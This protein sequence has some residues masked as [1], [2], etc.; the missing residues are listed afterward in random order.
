[1]LHHTAT[2]TA[3]HVLVSLLHFLYPSVLRAEKYLISCRVFFTYRAL[4]HSLLSARSTTDAPRTQ[5][6]PAR[7]PSLHQPVSRWRIHF[8]QVA[9]LPNT[10]NNDR[11]PP[12][13]PKMSATATPTKR[14]VLGS[15]DANV[16]M[17]PRSPGL[18][19]GSPLKKAGRDASL[20]LSRCA[21]PSPRKQAVSREGTPRKR[22]L[23][24]AAAS[25]SLQQQP[26][27]KKLCSDDA[28]GAVL[29][30]EAST[31][32]ADN[33]A[34]AAAAAGRQQTVQSTDEVRSVTFDHSFTR[35][36]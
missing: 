26:A 28:A 11:P 34:D 5:L 27:V 2:N 13:Q 15:L 19:G 4:T 32:A 29:E 22:P 12:S 9:F 10:T 17:S 24:E 3:K 31:T 6:L 33:A 23:E 18:G 7:R 36:V 21:S 1:M 30:H 20:S 35:R 16:Q 25:S 8:P 14:R